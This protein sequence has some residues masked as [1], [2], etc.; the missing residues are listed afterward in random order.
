MTKGLCTVS[1][2]RRRPLEHREAGPVRTLHPCLCPELHPDLPTT[3]NHEQ[4]FPPEAAEPYGGFGSVPS[5]QQRDVNTR[6]SQ[7]KCWEE[8]LLRLTTAQ[9]KNQR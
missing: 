5:T 1:L 4:G 7:Q 9:L 6:E 8:K 2:G 3:R